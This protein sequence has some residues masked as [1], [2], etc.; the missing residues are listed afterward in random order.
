MGVEV[1]AQPLFH[2]LFRIFFKKIVFKGEEGRGLH[3]I[4]DFCLECAVLYIKELIFQVGLRRLCHRLVFGCIA[5]G[6]P[7]HIGHQGSVKSPVRGSKIVPVL[8]GLRPAVPFAL[9][10]LVE[11]TASTTLQGLVT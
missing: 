11:R 9:G 7:G 1:V 6:G 10:I 3:G 5:A 8:D 2:D 4:E